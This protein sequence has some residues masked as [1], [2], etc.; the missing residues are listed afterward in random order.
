M[1][2]NSTTHGP[3]LL[4]ERSI[5][6]IAVHPIALLTGIF[7]AGL[8]YLVSRNDFTR[9]NAR[10]ALNWHLG[11]TTL[12]LV[13]VPTFFLGANDGLVPEPLGTTLGLVGAVLIVILMIAMAVTF[14]ASLLATVKAIFG[15]AWEYPVVPDIVDYLG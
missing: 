14:V 5:T 12:I 4:E 6:G 7:G 9:A 13:A 11:L 10:N 15:S 8:I 1:T 2:A 3:K